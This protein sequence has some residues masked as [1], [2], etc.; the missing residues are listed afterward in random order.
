[1]TF[2]ASPRVILTLALL[3]AVG[4]CDAKSFNDLNATFGTVKKTTSAVGTTAMPAAAI[5]TSLGAIEL[6]KVLSAENAKMASP[7]IAAA[8]G[9]LTNAS[10]SG[11]VAA[12]AGNLTAGNKWSLLQLTPGTNVE[13]KI[14]QNNVLAVVKYSSTAGADGSVT[15]AI[16]SFDGKT[17]GYDIKA[18]GSFTYY[19]PGTGGKSY[20][21]SQAGSRG[22]FKCGMTGEISYKSLIVKLVKLEFAA[23]D[24]LP[25][26]TTIGEFVMEGKDG[27]SAVAIEAS[28]G[29]NDDGKIT[30]TGTLKQ[31]GKKD[32]PI[33]FDE[34]NPQIAGATEDTP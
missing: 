28:V 29:T 21:I 9:N 32:K 20:T 10:G 31:A 15:S 3:A 13:K 4:G 6:I 17:N 12:G 33:K 25:N 19:P 26:G 5:A 18:K 24:P 7:I 1:M 27:S 8:A 14:E 11:I 23:T 34:S 16:D 30:A 22:S 2:S